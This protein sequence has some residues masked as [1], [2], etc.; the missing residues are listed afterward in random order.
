VADSI[1]GG[2]ALIEGQE[3]V[4][5]SRT[6]AYL[7]A[8]YGPPGLEISGDCG[9]PQLRDLIGCDDD[10]YL[11]P[12][13]DPAPWHDP[14]FPESADFAGFL[15]DEFTGGIDST[16]TREVFPVISGGG[17]LGRLRAQPRTMTWR[18]FLF[19]RTCC[20]V[21]Y[22]LRW[23]TSVLRQ[24]SC[25]AECAGEKIEFLVCC[26]PEDSAIYPC[27]GS[28]ALGIPSNDDAFRTVY[29]A[30]LLEGPLVKKE[31]R[32]SCS[33]GCSTIMEIE[34]SIVAGNPHLFRQ[35]VPIIEG[36]L[37]PAA[38][39]CAEFV[40]V[41]DPADCPPE[42]TCP[43]AI[44]CTYD[45]ACLQPNLPT[46]VTMTDECICDPLQPVELQVAVPLSTY[47]ANFQGVP[48]FHIYSGSDALRATTIRIVENPLGLDCA[49]AA[50][51]PCLFCDSISVRY[52]PA[53][54]TL[55]IDGVHRRITI[56]CPGGEVQPGEAFLVGDFSW[57][58]FECI[59]YCITAVIDGATAAADASF[60]LYVVPR[61]M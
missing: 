47:G 35:P 45:P 36:E 15:M 57:P 20:S 26:P 39:G 33:C 40:E 24:S 21:A 14:A 22:G 30:G 54:S 23:L 27:A 25:N 8:G 19:G 41:D 49:V 3:F 4:N 59:D 43:E 17:I 51:D 28:A 46:F 9:C 6:L 11:A 58:I 37:F 29:N 1:A 13:L 53:H 31:R 7:Q 18:G 34:F 55:K 50:A 2:A 61:E 12:D 38:E 5:D 56:E 42:D 52:I 16:Y 48:V 44:P 60:S 10:P 32:S